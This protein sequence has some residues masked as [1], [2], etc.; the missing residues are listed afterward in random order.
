MDLEDQ[1]G[2]D[3]ENITEDQIDEENYFEAKMG[4][5]AVRELLRR[6]DIKEE[7]KNLMKLLEN[8][9]AELKSFWDWLT[10]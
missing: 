10:K 2:I 3:S 8:I 7:M 6:L 5:E 4:G 1:F 9:E